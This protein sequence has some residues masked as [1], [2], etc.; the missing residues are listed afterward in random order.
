VVHVAPLLFERQIVDPLA[1][2]RG[3]EGEQRHD[4]RLPAGEE[5][6]AVR[7]RRDRHLARDR[8]DVLGASAVRAPLVD[9]DLSAHELLVDRLGRLLHEL[10]RQRVLHDRP[11]AVDRGGTDRER[12]LDSLGDAVEEQ[13]ALRRLELLRVLL[14]L[15]Q[16]DEVVLELL[17]DVLL[18]GFQP[19]P[20]LDQVEARADLDLADDVVLG[21]ADRQLGSELAHQLLDDGACLAQPL[22]VDPVT[23]A[24][25]VLGLELLGQ[26]GLEPL[27]LP[28][29]LAELLLRLAEL[30]DLAVGELEGLEH[31]VLG[32]LVGAGFD[33]RQRLLRADDDQVEGRV[34]LGLLQSRVDDELTVD[35]AD[36]HSAHRP[37]EGQR[38]HHQRGRGAVDAQD[39]V[40]GDEIGAED[41]ADHLHFVL[42]ARRPQRPDRAVDHARGQDRALGRAPF[43]L[44]ET[45]GNLPGG[46]HALFDVNGEREEVRAFAGLHPPRGGREHHR[47]ARADDDCA[48]GLLGELAGLERDVLVAHGH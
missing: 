36:P 21:R 42:V 39:V 33:H 12:Q 35:A 18:D 15:G 34:L 31:R 43:A 10:L 28:R 44:E 41:R 9:S 6:R 32:D 38:R 4:L 17:A 13:L 2:F 5:R 40:R 8:A 25:G 29:L 3:A 22:G 46:V 1:L 19:D 24:L 11:G 23:E 26:V 27:R 45:A 30:H 48:V 7:P 20:L 16:G 14:R 37:E 47:L